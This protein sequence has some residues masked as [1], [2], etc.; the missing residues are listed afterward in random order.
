M[1]SS[2]LPEPFLKR[3]RS[4]LEPGLYP[5][6]LATF[7]E[8]KITTFRLNGLKG[9]DTESIKRLQDLGLNLEA[10]TGLENVW[11]VKHDQRGLLIS[12]REF[13]T[14]QIYVQN[15][16]S[17]IPPMILEPEKKDRIL[18]MTAAPGSKTLQLA[19]MVDKTGQIVAIE[20][21]RNR[22]YKL[23]DNLQKNGAGF[24]KT[25][26]G[27]GERVWRRNMET[28]D[29]VLLDAPCSTEGRFLENDP[30]TYHY[31]SMRKVKEMVRKQSRLLF[32]AVQCL[33]PGG[34]LVYSTC[35][36][37]PEENEGVIDRILQQFEGSLSIEEIGM[38]KGAKF[39]PGL[40][41]W[42]NKRFNPEVERA[43]RIL[44][45]HQFEGFFVCR[46]RKTSSTI[47]V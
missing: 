10:V 27:D 26:L 43:R 20:K 12:S 8:E 17:M 13:E 30:E 42:R 39:T 36:F 3:L 38:P 45:D 40:T 31:W 25:F 41:T 6:V 32:S 29:R 21:V 15:V 37:A 11:S 1:S 47:G 34:T 19:E 5:S 22:F 35:T 44:P 2:R 4:I 18:D 9:G 46:I 14:G 24:V 16:S 28:F 7:S 23:K 33:K